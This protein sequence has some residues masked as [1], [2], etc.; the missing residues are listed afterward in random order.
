MIIRPIPKILFI[1]INL[2]L[3]LIDFVIKLS[4]NHMQQSVPSS[5]RII[6]IIIYFK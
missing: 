3:F 6:S 2:L 1:D 4:V 5:G